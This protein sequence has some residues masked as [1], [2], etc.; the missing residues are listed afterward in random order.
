[1]RIKR[2]LNL[3]S[4]AAKDVIY[5]F[6]LQIVDKILPLVVIPYLM[7]VLGSE[8]Y[9]Y[10]GFSSAVI[11]YI[12]L[13]VD[14]GFNLSA[15]KKIAVAQQ[16]GKLE[17]SKIFFSTFYAKLILLF[18][19][20]CIVLIAIVAIASIKRYSSTILCM[21]PMV[22]GTVLTPT[23][24]FQGIGRIR[25]LAIISSLSKLIILPL[26]FL[27][28]NDNKDYNLA[29]LIQSS[30]YFFAGLISV[31][32]IIR[33]KLISLVKVPISS[34]KT[35][36]QESFPLFL[37]S[38]ATSAYTQLFTL[39]L[40]LTS[41]P[42]VV[43]RYSSAEK[44]MRSLC[45]AIYN[46]INTAFYPR[47]SSLSSKNR[48]EAYR[49]LNKLVGLVLALMSLLSVVL[50]LFAKPISIVLGDGYEGV[51]FLLKILSPAPIAIAL[52]AVFGQMGLVAMGDKETV[53][54]FRTVYL[55]AALISLA[56]V[57]I[58]SWKLGDIGAA[59]ALVLTEYFV[60]ISMKY[61]YKKT[62]IC[63]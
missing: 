3:K 10:I 38:A 23:W 28:V 29:A 51:N 52:G 6:V 40:G 19:S 44:I 48:Q 34:I 41:T 57:T 43:G 49:K 55:Y 21:Y 17:V 5:L 45:F 12:I 14:F 53:N 20:T 1:M 9:G 33:L 2:F 63:F 16:Q 56:L 54:H 4:E 13:I 32:I 24:L 37:S 59:I 26:I 15:T 46:P 47:V 61:L 7:I 25:L 22:I 11:Q 39:I 30:V 42:D 58:L 8:K 62:S 60:F 27:F 50:F 35:E 31:L 18:I 36:I